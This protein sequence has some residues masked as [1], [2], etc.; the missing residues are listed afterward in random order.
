MVALDP[1]SIIWCAGRTKS[2]ASALRLGLSAV[3]TSY[4]PLVRCQLFNQ[5][6][7][8]YLNQTAPR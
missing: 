5:C 2:V 1:M 7:N 6:L 8:I 3:S 4:A